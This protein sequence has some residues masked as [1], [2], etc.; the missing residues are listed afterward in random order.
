MADFIERETVTGGAVIDAPNSNLALREIGDRLLW[1]LQPGHQESP[2]A[3]AQA[4]FGAVPRRGEVLRK[5][6]LRLLYLWP[7]KAWLLASSTGQ[8]DTLDDFSDIATDIGHGLCEFSLGG[9]NALGFLGS[10]CSADPAGLCDSEKR[11]LRCLLGQYPVVL[12]W[13]DIDDIRILVERSLA[14][15]FRDYVTSLMARWSR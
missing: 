6:S 3:L 7:H 10:Y 11:S 14:L 13:D 15:S 5:N 4:L 9:E 12:W 8:P 2:G 1:S